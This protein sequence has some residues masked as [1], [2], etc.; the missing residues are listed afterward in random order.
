[1]MW[2]LR[3]SG[4][5]ARRTTGRSLSCEMPMRDYRHT[6]FAVIGGPTER[7]NIKKDKSQLWLKANARNAENAKE[8]DARE[9][10]NNTRQ[11]NS[12][13]PRE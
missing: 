3:Q 2:P 13:L 1:M 8:G 11:P 9:P 4:T 12:H 5:R 7:K 10:A 6:R